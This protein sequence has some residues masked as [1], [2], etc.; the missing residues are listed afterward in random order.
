[1]NF[2]LGLLISEPMTVSDMISGST[3]YALSYFSSEISLP[4]NQLS[5]LR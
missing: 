5:L 1:M 3:L 4:L 2:W